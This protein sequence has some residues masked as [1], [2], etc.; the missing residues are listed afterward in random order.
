MTGADQQ[1]ERNRALPCTDNAGM[2][3]ELCSV[4]QGVRKEDSQ[5][6]F[7]GQ[8][9]VFLNPKPFSPVHR[10]LKF[11]AVRGTTFENSSMVMRPKGSSLAETLKYT[12]G[13]VS[14]DSSAAR[15]RWP[16]CSS[17]KLCWHSSNLLLKELASS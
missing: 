10:A 2:Q 7:P 3:E 13:L 12:T 4:F 9:V 1:Q 15:E 6:S 11:S 8:N 16:F 17:D 5:K 14:F